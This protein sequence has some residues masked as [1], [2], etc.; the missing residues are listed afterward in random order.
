MPDSVA[1]ARSCG[2]SKSRI[3]LLPFERTEN[4]EAKMKQKQKKEEWIRFYC[5]G[6]G[7]RPDGKGSAIAWMHRDTHQEHFELMDG[8]TNNQAE[9]RAIL[10]ALK[11][12][13]KGSRVQILNDSQVVIYQLSGKFRVSESGLVKL[14]GLVRA[15][16][17]E[18]VLAVQ[19]IWIPRRQNLADKIIQAG[20]RFALECGDGLEQAVQRDGNPT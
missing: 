4:E 17:D 19:F 10:S 13:P 9:Y 3:L 2:F 20:K 6:S 15:V 18:K 14:F 16:I 11:S 8:L 12:V 5:D 7:A 1:A